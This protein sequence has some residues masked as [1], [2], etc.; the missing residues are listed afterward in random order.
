M[1]NKKPDKNEVV[2]WGTGKYGELAYYYYKDICCIKC[3]I[4]SD[5]KKWGTLFH[6][7]KICSPKELYNLNSQ[8]DIIIAMKYC[9]EV[10]ERLKSNPPKN[11]IRV[12]QILNYPYELDKKK[13]IY[14]NTIVISFCGGLGNQMFQYALF[15]KLQHD[16]KR[17]TADLEYY[18]SPGITTKFLLPN[19][20]PNIKIENCSLEQ[21]KELLLK[22]SDITGTKRFL[23]YREA[24][25]TEVGKK[26]AETFL[27]DITGGYIQGY[28][29]SYWFAESIRNVLVNDFKFRLPK[30]IG[31]DGI[32]EKI[33]HANVV[34]IHIRRG[35]YLD[36]DKIH[37]YGNICIDLYY[38]RAIQYIQEQVKDVV[39]CFFSNDIEWVKQK[40]KRSEERRVGKECL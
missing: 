35:D 23:I 28:H 30:D 2:I 16:G 29:Q 3:C 13:H 12:F 10:I 8:I 33:R 18:L 19:I 40:F 26:S 31:L 4:D 15:R 38:K 25:I 11:F 20:F 1:V 14:E 9:D 5:E 21:K 37:I 7:I 39:L 24:D 6:G 34:S 17:V 32:R 27:L 22:N 36:K